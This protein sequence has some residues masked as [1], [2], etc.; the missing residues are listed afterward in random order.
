MSRWVIV[1]KMRVLGQT[2]ASQLRVKLVLYD[3]SVSNFECK[4]PQPQKPINSISGNF[5]FFNK[6]SYNMI[7]YTKKT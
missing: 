1:S 6:F 2:K 4:M 5:T 3:Y 7:K